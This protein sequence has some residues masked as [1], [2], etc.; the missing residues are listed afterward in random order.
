MYA[1]ARERIQRDIVTN[2]EHTLEEAALASLEHWFERRSAVTP[3]WPPSALPVTRPSPG[4]S[5]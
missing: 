4:P 5:S 1:V 3:A 2:P